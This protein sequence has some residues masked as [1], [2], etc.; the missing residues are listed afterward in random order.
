M[1]QMS[2]GTLLAPLGGL[3]VGIVLTLSPLSL[4]GI[5]AS[6]A[7]FSPG[8]FASDGT[9]TRWP[10]R[11]SVPVVIAFV[12]GMDAVLAV[13]GYVFVEV[14]IA[15]TRASV[16]MHLLA[17]SLLGFASVRLLSGR[18]SLCGRAQAIPPTPLRAFGFG[19]LFSVTGCIGCG[20]IVIGLASATALLAGPMSA[21]LALTAFILGR[22]A[23]LLA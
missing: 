3:L 9:R 10:L 11:D 14:T 6:V 22:S 21:V 8:R 4:P 20:P 7:T 18:H 12:A 16:A 15:L 5:A 17:A 2:E 1:G 13:L 23:V 19:M